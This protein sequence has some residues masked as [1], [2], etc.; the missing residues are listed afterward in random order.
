MTK[1]FIAVWIFAIAGSALLAVG[2]GSGNS[3]SSASQSENTFVLSEFTI[4]PPKHVLESGHV[5]ITADNVGGEVHEL[6]ILRA[7]EVETLSKKPDGS[8][9]EEK[10]AAN[11]KI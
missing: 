5:T 10:I 3:D 4:V 1:R 7:G 9:D 11:D 2:C 6:V 8:L